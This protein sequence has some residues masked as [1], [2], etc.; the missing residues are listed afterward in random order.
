MNNEG[1]VILGKALLKDSKLYIGLDVHKRSW[2]VTIYLESVFQKTFTQPPDADKLVTY[3]MKH[4]C[5]ID[6]SCAY[7]SGRF[8]FS[9][10]RK[11]EKAGWQCLVVNP[12]DIPR[13]SKQ[14]LEKTDQVDSRKIAHC[15][16]S[17]LL[18]G[19]YVPDLQQEDDRYIPRVR[20]LI[21][22]DL[23]R[24]KNRVKG[25]LD[26][27]G[28]KIPEEYDNPH[29][30]QAFLRWLWNLKVKGGL[31]AALQAHLQQI[32]FC[33]ELNL[34]YQ[35]KMK[36]LLNES[37]YEKLSELLQSIPGIGPLTA[38]TILT[39]VGDIHRFE[40]FNHFNSW[41]GLKPMS[42]SSGDNDHRGHLT[43]RANH[44]VR[45]ALVESSW[46]L[47]RK[48]PVI[49]LYFHR[50]MTQIGPKRAIIAVARKLA[51]RLY[52]VWKKEEMYKPGIN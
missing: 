52:H 25:L 5:G 21:W 22:R 12:G 20:K 40:H 50:K 4:Y 9:T 30:S 13:T 48:D 7:E 47:V 32:D 34:E 38:A 29:W 42:H 28:I 18:R 10:Q 15:L 24:H 27:A 19:I 41:L 45:S 23:T 14:V 36:G 33:H 31:Q 35:Q 39:E 44:V 17:G 43:Y 26:Y 51:S 8:G 3:I 11:L 6:V 2:S 49:G 46:T 16:Q 37:R 1:S